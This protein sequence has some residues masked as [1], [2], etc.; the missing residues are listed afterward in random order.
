MLLEEYRKKRDFGVTKEP[1][2]RFRRQTGTRI[3]V[4]QKHNASRL[5]Y[6]FR[7]EIGGVLVSWAVP[8]GPSLDP[9][10]KR[11]AA[12]TEDHPLEYAGFEG[13]I[14]EGEYGA[15]T[16]MVWD[17]GTFESREE[18][19]S[20]EDQL[21]RGEIKI[22]LHGDKLKGAFVLIHTGRG[23]PK[24]RDRRQWLLIKQRDV[25]ARSPWDPENPSWS[26]SV[27]TG[28]TLKEIEHGRPAK[29]RAA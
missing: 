20:V 13:I 4:V 24:L 27:L 1:R 16:V 14:P 28:R 3:F 18:G 29:R 7:L 10:A 22:T 19:V 9:S 23:T 17:H 5:H 8:K 12:M 6:D 2:G 21:A 25:H 26:R 11:L 15:G